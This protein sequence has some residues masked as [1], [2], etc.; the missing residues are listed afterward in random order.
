VFLTI[1]LSNAPKG[2]KNY[3]HS[4]FFLRRFY[5]SLKRDKKQ[6]SFAVKVCCSIKYVNAIV[7]F[8]LIEQK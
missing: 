8:L 1:Q 2:G 7:F 5:V 3:L 4:K 6:Q